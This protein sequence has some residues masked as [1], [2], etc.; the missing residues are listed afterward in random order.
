MGVIFEIGVNRY[1][2]KAQGRESLTKGPFEHFDITLS[3]FHI[4]GNY[5]ISL[6]ML[7]FKCFGL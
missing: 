6:R 5:L 2:K 4:K 1:L 7:S 3:S